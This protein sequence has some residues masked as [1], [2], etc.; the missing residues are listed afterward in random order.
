MF[1]R[2]KTPLIIAALLCTTLLPGM[3]DNGKITGMI[4]GRTGEIVHVSVPQPVDEGSIFSVKPVQADPPIAKAR[5]LSCTQERPYIALAK[6]VQGDIENPVPTGARAYA[7]DDSVK[8]PS[9]PKP[10]G[11]SAQGEDRF[12]MQVGAFYPS[13]TAL[14]D[15]VADY[16]QAYRLN[17]LL[18][19][20]RDFEA[21]LSAEYNKGSGEFPLE[22]GLVKRSREVIPL[23]FL[24]RIV[25]LRMGSTHLFLAAGPGF[26]KIRSEETT[27]GIT[28]S[29][30]AEEF[31]QE[32][33]VGFESRRGWI[34]E[35][36][37][38]DVENTDIQ[39]YSLTMGA[40]F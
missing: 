4:V 7:E 36:R 18:L 22:T 29:G 40:R 11:R 15:S 31:G 6:I 35:L 27:G 37:Y 20:A 10:M 3:A 9:V 39:G 14:R 34:L 2:C 13:T 28:T 32:Y 19:K 26:Y 21:Q 30:D 25:P 1:G 17:Y 8:G 33:A 5:V 38:R 12:S 16:W 24:G 23:T